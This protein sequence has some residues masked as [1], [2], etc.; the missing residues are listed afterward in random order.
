MAGAFRRAANR[1]VVMKAAAGVAA[2]AAS[3][4]GVV[5]GVAPT[6]AQ[7]ADG[8]RARRYVPEENGVGSSEA[9][10]GEWIIFQAEFPF[11]ALGASWPGDVGLWPVIA[12]QVSQDGET[13]TDTID[14]A[15]Q[16]DDGGQPSRD[17]RLF[18]A[19]IF[20]DGAQWVRYQ[21]IDIERVPGRVEGLE[22]TYIDPT[23]GP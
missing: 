19:L 17:G 14:V 22:F 23:D 5:P 2:L 21:T 15:A 20:T 9:A 3:G 6:L 13:W 11:W 16:T 1:R 7:Q 12:V 10:Q 18:T 4:I 8:T